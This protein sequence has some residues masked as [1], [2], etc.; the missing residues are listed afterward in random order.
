M[1]VGKNIFWKQWEQRVLVEPHKL[2]VYVEQVPSHVVLTNKGPIRKKSG[3]DFAAGIYGHAA[4]FDAKCTVDKR[5]NL[6]SKAIAAKKLHQFNRLRQAASMGNHAGYLIW[7]YSLGI[8]TWAPIE[9][10][11]GLIQAGVRSITPETVGCRNQRD[12][13]LLD[14]GKLILEL[15]PPAPA[16]MRPL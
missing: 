9:V 11:T 6:A 13:R 10:L 3:P 12:N 8:I 14:L 1:K 5:F 2:D 15:N 16:A 7:F 4:F